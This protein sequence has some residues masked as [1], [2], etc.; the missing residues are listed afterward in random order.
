M[1][2]VRQGSCIKCGMCCKV[3]RLQVPK[4]YLTNLDVKHWVELHGVKLHEADGGVWATIRIPC[5]ALT[6]EGLC[7]LHG[8]PDRP[9]LCEKWPFGPRDL[10]GLPECSY[11]Y[12]EA[13]A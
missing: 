3:L 10:V 6:P 1:A 13:E 7:S 4:P 11:S 9:D 8:T 2:L 5:S 12:V